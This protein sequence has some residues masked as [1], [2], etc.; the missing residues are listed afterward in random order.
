MDPQKYPLDDRDMPDPKTVDNPLGVMQPGEKVI[1]EIKRHPIGLV[2]VY[3]TSGITLAATL[4]I[5]ILAPTYVT[6][7]TPQQRLGVVLASILGMV[8]I[9]IF[10]YV[11]L[12][13][14]SANRI[15]VTSDSI[16]EVVQSG[17]FDRHVQQLSLANLEDVAA[18]Q[19]GILQTLL[20]YGDLIVESAGERSHFTFS[21]CPNP[22]EYA[23]K[24]IAAHEEFLAT[25]KEEF[26]AANQPLTS[27]K[28][29]NQAPPLP[30][31]SQDQM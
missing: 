4:S 6:F 15:I 19:E 29:Y 11:G 20:G 9:L 10:T 12:F 1:C 27:V 31:S 30:R 17:L 28:G 7:L 24:I 16:T 14:Y 3:A 5:A 13:L 23:R 22:N 26:L 21:Y 2:G 18:Q 25:R 8:I